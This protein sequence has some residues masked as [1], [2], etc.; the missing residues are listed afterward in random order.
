MVQSKIST[1]WGTVSATNHHPRDTTGTE[2]SSAYRCIVAQYGALYCSCVDTTATARGGA[3]Q[4]GSAAVPQWCS[5]ELRMLY[6]M[7]AHP[8]SAYVLLPGSQTE[9][10][11]HPWHMYV[12]VQVA[13]RWCWCALLLP[14]R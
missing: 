11:M 13:A 6:T 2:R 12:L 8:A 4:A 1:W 3:G 7:S 9:L 10:H 14:C 5:D